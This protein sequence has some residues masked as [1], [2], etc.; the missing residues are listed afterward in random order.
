MKKT[1]ASPVRLPPEAA[2]PIQP[3]VPRKRV[4]RTHSSLPRGT[5]IPSP[6]ILLHASDH[7]EAR[8]VDS[9]PAG[10]SQDKRPR[11][12]LALAAGVVREFP[13]AFLVLATGAV[14]A[15]YLHD[16]ARVE[17]VKLPGLTS[18]HPFRPLARERVR[19]LRQR[20][21]DTLFDAFVP[22]LL[23]FDAGG[24]RPGQEAS[25][26]LVRAAALKTSVLPKTEHQGPLETC[27]S[28]PGEARLDVC[29]DCL[30][31]T[32]KAVR[33]ALAQ[34]GLASR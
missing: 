30:R 11:R 19:R 24:S 2:L 32:V 26:L 14:E 25:R 12:D 23:L 8:P 28:G 13:R 22:D 18:D 17:V 27:A 10:S 34:R 16:T 21:L 3:S 7:G 1:H 6:R 33:R 20:L 5:H 15:T 31:A 4:M 9:D 29:A